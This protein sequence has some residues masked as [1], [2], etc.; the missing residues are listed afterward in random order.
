MEGGQEGARSLVAPTDDLGNT[1]Q[2]SSPRVALSAAR[3]VTVA[4]NT[5]QTSQTL[6][7]QTSQTLMTTVTTTQNLAGVHYVR[8]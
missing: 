6:M 8:I 3:D 5:S 7:T 1:V 2:C 4:G